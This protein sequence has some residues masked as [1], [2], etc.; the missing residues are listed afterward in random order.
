MGAP[1]D[2]VISR[3][4]HAAASIVRYSV[5]ESATRPWGTWEVLA[6][7]VGYTLKRIVVNPGQRL[8]LQYH[9]H[10][11]EHWTV[12][13]GVAEVEINGV[14]SPLTAG[15]NVYVPLGAHHRLKNVSD[16]PMVLIE[17]QVGEHLDENDIIRLEDDYAR[18]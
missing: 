2:Q 13:Q 17:V 10:R 6:T 8:S 15:E 3:S 5:G 18:V 12:V 7:G 1:L 11:A 4:A 16:V 14:R 9:H